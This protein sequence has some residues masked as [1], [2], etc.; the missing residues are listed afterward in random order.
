MYS[1]YI[2]IY[3]HISIPMYYMQH[4]WN[5]STYLIRDSYVIYHE[6]NKK[7]AFKTLT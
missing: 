7:D 4:V 2:Y 3:K 6:G 1:I 5:M